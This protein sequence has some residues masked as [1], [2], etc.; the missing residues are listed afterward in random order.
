MPTAPVNGIDLYYEVEGSGPTVVFAHG[1]GGNHASWHNQVPRFSERYP[2][3]AF[4][5]E[6]E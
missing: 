5:P 1:I 4:D 2:V 3:V 6:V